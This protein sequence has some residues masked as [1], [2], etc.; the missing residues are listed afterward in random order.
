MI[1]AAVALA[2]ASISLLVREMQHAPEGIE[3]EKGLSLVEPRRTTRFRAHP[4][5]PAPAEASR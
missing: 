4:I 5:A 1:F 2:A 3:D